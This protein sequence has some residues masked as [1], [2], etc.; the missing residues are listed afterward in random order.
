M[1]ERVAF[2]GTAY[3][4]RVR[5]GGCF[6][7][8]LINGEPG[9]EHEELLY[10]DNAH[11]AFLSRYPTLRGCALVA[12]RRHLEDVVRDLTQD[13]YIAM[14]AVVHR[15]A[16]AI[17]EVVPTERTYVLSLGS[18]Q[19]NAHIHWHIAPLPPGVPYQQQQYHAL[20]AENGIL[21]QT[22]IETAELGA[23]VRA[24]MR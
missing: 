1:V 21:Q 23:A 11:V 9:S 15:V 3:E 6:I 12:P 20:M 16:C 4:R 13:E 22:P 18:M 5:S 19:G 2:D 17:N 7:C 14:Q 10:D 8:S 24:A